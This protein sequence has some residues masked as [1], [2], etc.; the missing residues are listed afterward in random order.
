MIEFD[1]NLLPEPYGFNNTGSIC[2]FN[3]LLQVLLSCTSLHKIT[4]NDSNSLEA[5]FN[6]VVR[7][8]KNLKPLSSYFLLNEL[9]SSKFGHG[10]ESASEALTLLLDNINNKELSN[11]FMHRFRYTNKCNECNY[12]TEELRDHSYLFEM[13]H[14]DEV[15][16]HKMSVQRSTLHDFPCSKCGKCNMTRLSLLTMLP[17]IICCLFNVYYIKKKH[18]FPQTL[19]FPGSSGKTLKYIL[20]GQIEHSGSLEGGHYWSRALRNDGVYLFNDNHYEPSKLE[21]T[22]NTYMIIYNFLKEV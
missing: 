18:N 21:P 17:E 6:S 15:T 12:T 7:N 1:Y 22:S 20:V 3:S 8:S 16:I 2:Y 19:E 10:Q 4:Y 5:V 9:Q 13:F 14:T 11:L